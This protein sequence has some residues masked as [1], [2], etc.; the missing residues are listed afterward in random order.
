M[1]HSRSLWIA[2]VSMDRSG[3]FGSLWSLW[4]TLDLYGSLWSLWIA[5]V[6]MDCSGLYGSLWSLWVALVSMDR[7][8]L[9]GLLWSLWITL[10]SMD[11]SGAPPLLAC[12]LSLSL[13]LSKINIKKKKKKKGT[14]R[15]GAQGHEADT[16]PHSRGPP[17]GKLS[18][19]VFFRAWTQ[20]SQHREAE[21][22]TDRGN[23]QHRE[24]TCN[25]GAKFSC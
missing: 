4:I 21:Q 5:L 20:W 25:S 15:L 18:H 3:L 16:L 24:L 8:D 10:I 6:S 14:K 7:S 23:K 13:S 17:L 22:G 12:S 1:N 2:L 19:V 11:R 9:C